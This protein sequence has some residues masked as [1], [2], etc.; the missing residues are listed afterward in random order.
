MSSGQS[1]NAMRPFALLAIKDGGWHSSYQ[2][3]QNARQ[4]SEP[5]KMQCTIHHARPTTLY[6][7]KSEVMYVGVAAYAERLSS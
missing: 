7:L 1:F 5:R 6:H 3:S 2:A 4:T